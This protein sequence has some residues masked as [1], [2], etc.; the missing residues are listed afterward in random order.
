MK[1]DIY[2]HI[3][4]LKHKLRL[5]ENQ[6]ITAQKLEFKTETSALRILKEFIEED[7]FRLENIFEKHNEG[8]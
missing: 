1:A 2:S 6:I 7:I 5:V 3:Q 4:N 8:K